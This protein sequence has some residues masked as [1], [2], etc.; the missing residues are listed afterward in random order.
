MVVKVRCDDWT[1]MM[2]IQLFLSV[3]NASAYCLAGILFVVC[4]LRTHPR[5]ARQQVR[6]Q[7]HSA[8]LQHRA[9]QLP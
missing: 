4:H 1:G 8:A 9:A 3:L 6:T 7:P 5:A 2:R